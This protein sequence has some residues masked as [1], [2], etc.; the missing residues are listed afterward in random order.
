MRAIE[1]GWPKSRLSP[2]DHS[3]SILEALAWVLSAL[4]PVAIE[5]TIETAIEILIDSRR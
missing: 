4:P 2:A 1:A 3:G 5:I